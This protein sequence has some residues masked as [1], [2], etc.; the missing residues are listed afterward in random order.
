MSFLLCLTKFEIMV[1]PKCVENFNK[2]S[3]STLLNSP[4]LWSV[5]IF[6]WC[7]IRDI[8]LAN[9]A[10]FSIFKYIYIFLSYSPFFL[11]FW[12]DCCV[13]SKTLIQIQFHWSSQPFQIITITICR[14]S[15][16]RDKLY[17]DLH[18]RLPL[19]G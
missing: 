14:H 1:S 13:F 5:S 16:Q 17:C 4:N 18:V 19:V 8:T 3:R 10:N 6:S 12:L 7:M 9:L 15:K 2:C 11:V